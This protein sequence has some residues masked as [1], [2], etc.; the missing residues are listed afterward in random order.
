[1]SAYVKS[2]VLAALHRYEAHSNEH[3][4]EIKHNSKIQQDESF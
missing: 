1:M 2:E 3:I 4:K